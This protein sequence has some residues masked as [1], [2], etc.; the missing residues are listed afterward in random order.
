MNMRRQQREAY[1]QLAIS[2]LEEQ[3]PAGATYRGKDAIV[4]ALARDCPP[5]NPSF[6]TRDR[7]AAFSHEATLRLA[8]AGISVCSPTPGNGY[9]RTADC[10]A[11]VREESR[12]PGGKQIRTRV[13][14]YALE[15]ESDAKKDDAT[16]Q[17]KESATVHK[18]LHA[19]LEGLYEAMP[20]LLT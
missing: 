14:N 15:L 19:M 16:E 8:Q 11:E 12:V 3:F 7:A 18:A 20:G 10:S 5:D 6:L 4:E 1:E 9:L 17:A 2:Y 13:A